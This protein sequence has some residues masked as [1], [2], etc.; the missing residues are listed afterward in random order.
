M[1]FRSNMAENLDNKLKFLYY[2]KSILKDQFVFRKKGHNFTCPSCKDKNPSASYTIGVEKLFC[3]ACKFKGTFIEVVKFLEPEKAEWN[4]S[5]IAKYLQDSHKLVL[6]ELNIDFFFDAYEKFGFDLV[7]LIKNTKRPFENDW[8]NVLHKDKVDWKRWIESG[9]NIGIKTGK[10]SN[11]T[12]VDIDDMSQVPEVFKGLTTMMQTTNKGVHYVFA[13]E[14]DLPNWNMRFNKVKPKLP[15]EILNTGRQCASYPT[16]VDNVSR[17]WNFTHLDFE[18]PKMPKAV[19]DFLLEH[20]EKIDGDKKSDLPEEKQISEDIKNDT[21]G[22]SEAVSS[23]GQGGRND[24][25]IRFGGVL[26]KKLNSDQTGYVLNYINKVFVKP[27]LAGTELFT[28]M[29]SIDKYISADERVLAKKILDYLGYAEEGT[30]RDIREALQEEKIDIDKGL[31]YLVREK[32]IIKKRNLYI[33]AKKMIWREDYPELCPEIKFKMPYFWD[34]A[35]FTNSDQIIIGAPTGTGKTTIAMNILKRLLDEKLNPHLVVLESGSRFIKIGAQLGIPEK[36]Y[37]WVIETNP[38]KIIPEPNSITII[39]WL[40]IED[41]TETQNVLQYFSEQSVLS[42]SLLIIFMQ[43]KEDGSWFAPNL[44]KNFSSFAARYLYEQD[45]NGNVDG[46]K[47]Y[48][49][50]DKI[51]EAKRHA[52]S[53]KIPCRYFPDTKVLSRIDEITAE[54]DGFLNT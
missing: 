7:P 47:G 2:L 10:P 22:S 42:N 34:I 54:D 15:I 39:D 8:S 37:K 19:K 3:Q 21:I 33:K 43:L 32:Y 6:A 14:E 11:I 52:K 50:V 26:R 25:L 45:A 27:P 23:V 5:Q 40:S 20:V 53:G 18:I 49:Q 12:V 35:E 44:V 4:A 31:S 48:W 13:F 24:F 51:R 16:K 46:L 17:S 28:L 30:S 38:S 29:G 41:F 9:F 36:S 1:T